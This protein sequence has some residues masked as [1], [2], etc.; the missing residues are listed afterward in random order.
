MLNQALLLDITCAPVF[1]RDTL[2]QLIGRDDA[3]V[4]RES[5]QMGLLSID[6]GLAR[7]HIRF[8]SPDLRRV[9]REPQSTATLSESA[10]TLPKCLLLFL[11]PSDVD[12]RTDRTYRFQC[13]RHTPV[14]PTPMN[15]HPPD[16]A[17]RASHAIDATPPSLV[18]SID[19]S[20]G[21]GPHPRPVAF[22]NNS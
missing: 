5:E 9:Q 16:R 11:E 12:D 8:E 18:G 17:V 1:Q 13:A 14:K 15:R 10:L 4:F 19:G 20:L 22:M 6:D 7:A 3:C 21:A 2:A